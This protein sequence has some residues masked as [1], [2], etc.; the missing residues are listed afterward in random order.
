MTATTAR[1]DLKVF[2]HMVA[3]GDTAHVLGGDGNPLPAGEIRSLLRRIGHPARLS[4]VGVTEGDLAT[5]AAL[6]LSDGAIVNNPRLVL[7]AEEV[8]AA[9]KAAF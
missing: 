8:L 7:D 1:I 5:A 9:Y 6:S 2:K 3:A 4:D